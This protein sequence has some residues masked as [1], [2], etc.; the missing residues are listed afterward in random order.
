MIDAHAQL[1]GGGRQGLEGVPGLGAIGGLRA[2]VN[3]A[4]AHVLAS[5]QFGRV[6]VQ[7]ISGSSSTSNRLACLSCVFAIRSLSC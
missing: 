2:K 7:R 4:F 1:L 3:I 5:A 6:V